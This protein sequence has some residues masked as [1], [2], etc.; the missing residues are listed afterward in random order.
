MPGGSVEISGQALWAD[1][2]PITNA[3]IDISLG[4]LEGGGYVAPSRTD[5]Q[6][7]FRFTYAAPSDVSGVASVNL[8]VRVEGCPVSATVTVYFGPAPTPTETPWAGQV[9]G[10][11]DETRGELEKKSKTEERKDKLKDTDDPASKAKGLGQQATEEDIPSDKKDDFN[12]VSAGGSSLPKVTPGP[13]SK[14]RV[15]NK[16]LDGL[17]EEKWKGDNPKLSKAISKKGVGWLKTIG[18][19]VWTIAKKGANLPAEVIGYALE[20]VGMSSVQM[21][22]NNHYDFYAE[23]RGD[24]DSHK[25]AMEKLR[26]MGNFDWKANTWRKVYNKEDY[27][28]VFKDIYEKY[29]E[30]KK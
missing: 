18:K 17:K 28:K 9:K 25:V 27:D 12:H 30:G 26:K 24:G 5:S 14:A 7:H 3:L 22:V 11:S 16:V 2:Q 1:G 21:T 8:A 6:G 23:K 15:H 20:K 29:G 13:I 10:I 4:G 19:A